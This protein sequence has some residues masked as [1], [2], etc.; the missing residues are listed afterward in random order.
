MTTQDEKYTGAVGVERRVK[1]PPG[2]LAKGH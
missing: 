2:I 1:V